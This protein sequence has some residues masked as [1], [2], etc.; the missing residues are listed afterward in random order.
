MAVSVESG[1][2][3]GV[4]G[5]SGGGG[6]AATTTASNSGHTILTGTD[7]Q[8]Q[9]DQTDAQLVASQ[10]GFDQSA[11][12]LSVQKI[13]TWDF[14]GAGSHPWLQSVTG[15][16]A[17]KSLIT[18]ATINAGV[19][20]AMSCTT[21]TTSSGGANYTQSSAVIY[22]NGAGKIIK[23]G[24]TFRFEDLNDGTNNY[25]YAPFCFEGS[26]G[27]L[28]GSDL[29]STGESVNLIYTPDDSTFQLSKRIST[30]YTKVNTGVTAAA[31]T[32]YHGYLEI[33]CAASAA[34]SVANA[35]LGIC[36]SPATLVATTTGLPTN[37]LGQSMN[38]IQKVLGNTARLGY[39]SDMWMA[40]KPSNA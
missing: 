13:W 29:R 5:G 1:V 9:L 35:Y 37:P 26:G 33:I 12:W 22:M 3:L 31:D 20:R 28:V 40:Y 15:T 17:A 4:R 11:G 2:S 34:N 6:T 27:S 18:D 24:C 38:F 7:V 14:T 39:F 16:G 21:G 25:V 19:T 36:G 30:T 32:W 8:T 23:A 10:P